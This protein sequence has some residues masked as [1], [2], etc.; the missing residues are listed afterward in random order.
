MMF[1]L[2]DGTQK[3]V[4]EVKKTLKLKYNPVPL[5]PIAPTDPLFIEIEQLVVNTFNPSLVGIGRD[6]GGL[7]HS[8]LAVGTNTFD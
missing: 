3:N 1:Q 6:G 5:V 8:C 7:D 2:A 4:L